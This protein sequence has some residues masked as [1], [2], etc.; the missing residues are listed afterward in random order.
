MSARVQNTLTIILIILLPLLAFVAGFLANE[1]FELPWE[2]S[3]PQTT[4]ETAEFEI[5]WEAWGHVEESYIGETP[6]DKQVTYAAIRGILNSL[7]DPYSIFLEPVVRQEEIISLSGNYGGIGVFIER[8]ADEDAFILIPIPDNPAALAGVEDGDLLIA[9]NGENLA[10][11]ISV[12]QID[13]QLRGEIGEE[14]IL[15]LEKATT[16]E[17][18]DVA[19]EFGSILVP[20]VF[21][22]ILPDNPEI[23]YIQLSRFSGESPEELEAAVGDLGGQGVSKLVLD[24]RGNGGGLLDASVEIA[25]QFVADGQILRQISRTQGEKLYMAEPDIISDLPL[26]V[27]V[28]RGTASAA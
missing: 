8:K 21:Y 3:A 16:G 26:V 6:Q 17:I 4:S 23:G 25:D 7:D 15:T 11:E 14:I 10:E 27:L 18:I 22:R 2:L 19:I 13:Q 20:S 5:F 28:N 12:D 9:I 24:L 1:L